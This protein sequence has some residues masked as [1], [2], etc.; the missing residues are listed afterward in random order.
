MEERTMK[1]EDKEFL[2]E[3]A[4]ELR[5][6]NNCGT[7]D[8]KFWMIREKVRTIVPDDICDDFAII[9]SDGEM[10]DN[11]SDFANHLYETYEY[12]GEVK[13][14]EAIEAIKKKDLN[15]ILKDASDL[16]DFNEDEYRVISYRNEWRIADYSG[17]FLTKKD[18]VEH[19]KKNRYHYGEDAHPY[20][21]YAERNYILERLINIIKETNWEE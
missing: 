3:L 7:R 14:E 11:T 16:Y 8:P 20:C 9:D 21:F 17:A 1:K 5:T 2:A 19:L 10:Y 4:K 18:A 13:E 12:C 15:D 6:Q